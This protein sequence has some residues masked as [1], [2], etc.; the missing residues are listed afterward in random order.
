MRNS[1]LFISHVH[2]LPGVSGQELRVRNSL[3]AAMEVFDEVTL[4]TFGNPKSKELLESKNGVLY[5]QLIFL[6]SIIQSSKFNF[7]HKLIGYIYP[8]ILGLKASNFYISNVEFNPERVKKAIKG[9]KFDL[10]LLEYFH[11]YRLSELFKDSIFV[12]DTH[13]ILWKVIERDLHSKNKQKSGKAKILFDRYRKVEEQ[14]WNHFDRILSINHSEHKYISN[15]IKSDSKVILMP[16]GIDLKDWEYCYNYNPIPNIGYYGGLNTDHNAKDALF[17][18]QNIFPKVSELY[19][20]S[21]CIIAGSK[22]P[23]ILTDLITENKIEIP[24]FVE[25]IKSILSQIQLMII[26]WKGQYGFRSRIIEI[27][28]CGIPLITTFDAVHGMDIDDQEGVYLCHSNDDLIQ[29]TIELLEKKVNLK[30][31]GLLA[32]NQ[33]ISKF[34]FDQTYIHGFKTLKDSI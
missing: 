32:R 11:A 29:K 34:S 2:P 1:I 20:S 12:L 21:K 23:K 6:P 14:S 10:I 26:P 15:H 24:G 33:A 19:P 25:D 28:A 3:L 7:I 4:L 22:P 16:M 30:E 9:K 31:I 13:N 17:V 27:M 18:I 5:H 8:F